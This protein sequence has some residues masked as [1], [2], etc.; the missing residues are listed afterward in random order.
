MQKPQ[1]INVGR[2]LFFWGKQANKVEESAQAAEGEL[3]K[4]G[5]SSTEIL[6][7]GCVLKKCQIMLIT[8]CN[9]CKFSHQR[10]RHDVMPSNPNKFG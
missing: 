5:L 1:K 7:V 4:A 10:H 9:V 8:L 2:T 6:L 3:R